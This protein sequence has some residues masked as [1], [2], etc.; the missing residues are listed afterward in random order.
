[1]P[2]A[3]PGTLPD[4]RQGALEQKIIAK[5]KNFVV[6]SETLPHYF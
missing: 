4:Q 3:D 2:K 5:G 1:M 6:D